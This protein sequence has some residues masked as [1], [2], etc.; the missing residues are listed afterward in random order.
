MCYMWAELPG[1]TLQKML[2]L[3]PIILLKTIYNTC[4]K[5]TS[6][7]CFDYCQNVCNTIRFGSLIYINPKHNY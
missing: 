1:L 5:W 6:S 2:Y 4:N 3:L 7:I